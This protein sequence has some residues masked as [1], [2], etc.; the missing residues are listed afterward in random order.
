M[1][2]KVRGPTRATRRDEIWVPMMIAIGMG[3]KAN[4]VRNGL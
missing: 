3:R 1:K 2:S 4:P